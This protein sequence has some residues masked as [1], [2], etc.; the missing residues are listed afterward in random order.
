MKN[1]E[2]LPI[3]AGQEIRFPIEEKGRYIPIVQEKWL[4]EHTI[5]LNPE[6]LEPHT[7]DVSGAGKALNDKK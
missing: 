7:H 2:V 4:N 3:K 5:G 1:S 6:L